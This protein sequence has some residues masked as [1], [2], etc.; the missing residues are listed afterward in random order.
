MGR[1]KDFLG[2][3]QGGKE[4]GPELLEGH[5]RFRIKGKRGIG[6]GHRARPNRELPAKVEVAEEGLRDRRG[7]R[8]ES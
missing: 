6:G 2:Q 5:S 3:D 1:T 4:T 7:W 8:E